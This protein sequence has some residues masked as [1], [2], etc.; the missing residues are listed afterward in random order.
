MPFIDTRAVAKDVRL[1][2]QSFMLDMILL[3]LVGYTRHEF[4]GDIYEFK[5]VAKQR[6]E[7]CFNH[8]VDDVV[9]KAFLSNLQSYNRVSM[10]GNESRG[11]IEMIVQPFTKP[12]QN[13]KLRN[14]RNDSRLVPC[15]AVAQSELLPV[16]T[17]R[18]GL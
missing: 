11:R 6:G 12:Q 18:S 15:I 17:R 1:L 5:D 4:S 10:E 8:F 7:L 13:P 2:Y 14:K 9:Y 3:K 16:L